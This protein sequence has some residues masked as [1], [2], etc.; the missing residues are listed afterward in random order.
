[1]E[2]SNCHGSQ[3]HK[4]RGVVEEVVRPPDLRNIIGCWFVLKTKMQHGELDKY[5]ARLVARGYT[6]IEKLDFNESFAPVARKIT[7]RIFLKK[8]VDLGHFRVTIDF[9]AVCFQQRSQ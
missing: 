9:V 8:S 3:E 7:L 1:V 4:D 6:Q 5:K 2:V